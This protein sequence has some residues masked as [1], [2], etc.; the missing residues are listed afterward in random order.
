MNEYRIRDF[1]V[2]A[3]DNVD[4]PPVLKPY[5]GIYIYY[6]DGFMNYNL[7]TFLPLH[8]ASGNLGVT[9]L[10]IETNI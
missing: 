8:S 9:N 7:S 10:K 1:V 4:C 5:H 6:I 3:S 2:V